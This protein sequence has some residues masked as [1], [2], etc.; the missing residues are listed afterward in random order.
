MRRSLLFAALILTLIAAAAAAVL[1]LRSPGDAP[2]A[3]GERSEAEGAEAAPAILYHC[4]MHPTVIADKPGDC[5]ICGMRLVPVES[6]TGVAPAGSDEEA[7][8]PP[9]EG[10][11]G[12]HVPSRKQ[13]LIGV[14]TTLA[15]RTV[16]R[17]VIRTVGRVVPDETR[18]HHVHT[19]IQ[20]WVEHL[21]VN[22]TGEKVRRGDP[23]LSVYS[24][25]L[26]ASQEEYLL[27]YRAHRSALETGS[28]D[29]ARRSEALLES[30]RRR[31]QLLDLTPGQIRR[32]EETG[33]A[34]RTITLYAPAS[35]HV[36]QRNVSQGQRIDAD[37]PLLDL[38]DLS[39]VW[40]LASIYEYELPF[41]K[42]GQRATMTLS[43]LPG[44]SYAG[45]V[46]LVYPVLEGATRTAQ[47]RLEFANP[48]LDLKPEMYANVELEGDLGVRLG[49]PATALLSSG[50]RDVVFVAEGDG[51]FEPRDLELGARGNGFVEVRAGIAEGERIVTTGNFLIDAE[52]NLRAALA[53]FTAPEAR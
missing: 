38:A 25:E 48:N 45:S 20:G 3:P 5:P 51:L 13:Q 53:A 50:T 19:K 11:S 30:A 32:L 15:A 42:Q 1:L 33:E 37:T 16:F 28:S 27:A 9:V 23:L 22:A 46:A 26:V 40:V 49:V 39:R 6:P 2:S 4:P 52:S 17:R 7:P 43:Y 24:P 34:A 10:R 41:V 36:L 31:L 47:V 14:R 29:L 12:V 18:L 44:G 21:N 35:G 8:A